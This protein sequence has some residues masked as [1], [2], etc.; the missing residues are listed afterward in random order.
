ML[1]EK[2]AYLFSQLSGDFAVE[3]PYLRQQ[4]CALAY[5]FLLQHNSTLISFVSEIIVGLLLLFSL[6][7][8]S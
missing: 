4:V 2:V 6:T 3:Q 5:D 7:V 8:A 1:V